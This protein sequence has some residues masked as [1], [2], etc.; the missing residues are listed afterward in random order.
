MGQV[1]NDLSNLE[2]QRIDSIKTQY[3]SRF[4]FHKVRDNG[5]N[6]SVLIFNN[7]DSSLFLFDVINNMADYK[8]VALADS[9]NTDE[10]KF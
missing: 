9:I 7:N 6:E 3:T 10:I 1:K 4:I 5:W 2:F 8:I